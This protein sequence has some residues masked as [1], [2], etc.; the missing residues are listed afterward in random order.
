VKRRTDGLAWALSGAAVILI[1]FSTIAAWYAFDLT[2]D[3]APP[4]VF[5]PIANAFATIVIAITGGLIASRA[6]RNPIGWLLLAEAMI[7]PAGNLA[8]V[9]IQVAEGTPLPLPAS[10]YAPAIFPALITLRIPLFAFM[11]LLFPDGRLPLGR[12]RWAALIVWLAV[13]VSALNI[14]NPVIDTLPPHAPFRNPF[15]IAWE[16]LQVVQRFFIPLQLFSLLIGFAAGISR[17]RHAR[18]AERQQLKWFAYACAAVAVS[19]LAAVATVLAALISGIDLAPDRM[20]YDLLVAVTLFIQTPLVFL[21]TAMAIAILRYRLYDIDL[22]INRTVVYGVTTGAIG[23]TFFAG[24]VVL[25]AL[26]HPFIS[27]SELAVAVSTLVSFALFQPLRARVQSAVDHRFYRT[28]YDA[29]RTLDEFGVRLRDEVD[30]DAVR[31]DLID[32]VQHT[33]QPVHASVWLR[34]V[35]S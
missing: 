9:Y 11:F 29:A 6:P 1:P 15:G 22:L 24:I 35:K 25:P 19:T 14:I 4:P 31:S 8:Q 23:L 2:P 18:G 3:L 10:E 16:P 28:R 17:F 5:V 30:L 21:P 32:A 13:A 27:G 26:L 20:P 33:V 12:W 34:E 7:Q